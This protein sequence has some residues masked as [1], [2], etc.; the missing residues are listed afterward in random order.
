[1]PLSASFCPGPM[2]PSEANVG[3][4]AATADC[5]SG[6][7][8]VRGPSVVPLRR[9]IPW[10]KL[11]QTRRELRLIGRLFVLARGHLWFLP[12]MA[13]LALLSAV[14]EGISL[15]LVIPLVQHLGGPA[16]PAS[17]FPP[18]AWFRDMIDALPP[19]TRL[20]AMLGA[21]LS[22][23]V[24]KSIVS[25][26]NMAVLGV[27][28]GR[29]SH[30]LRTGIFARILERPL[31][32]VE[33]EPS[34]RLLNVLNSETWRATD[35][36]NFLFTIITSSTTI[37]VFAALL[38]LLSWR[39]SLI[40]LLC[41]AAI[42][43]LI[44]LIARRAKSLS[45]LGLAANE[46]LARHTWTAL[47]GLR[48]IHVFGRE[49]FEARRL[50]ES[51][52][53]VRRQLLKMVLISTASGPVTEVLVT[54]IVA[55]LALLV[56]A[57]QLGLGILAG[58]LAILYRLQPRLV[59]L[60]SAQA[61]LLGLHASVDAVYEVF[62]IPAET[63]ESPAPRRSASLRERVSFE[64]VSFTY[65]GASRPALLDVSLQVRR[66][67]M[68][69]IVGPSGAG[70]STVLDLLLG[71]QRAQKGTIRVDDVPLSACDPVSWRARLAVVSQDPYVFDDTVR[72]NILYGRPGA[73]D[74]QMVAAARLACADGFI[75]ELPMG[76]D[77]VV[78]ERGAQISGGQRQRIALARALVRDP[79]ILVLDEATN[80]LDAPTERAFQDALA[81]FV[82]HRAVLVVAHRLSTVEKAD[83]V[84]VLDQGR[85][86]EEGDPRSLLREGGRFSHM[87]AS[88]ILPSS[89]DD[90]VRRAWAR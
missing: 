58:F 60:V 75:R 43:P 88:Q 64:N 18:L 22:A 52:D 7:V 71:F 54:G 53:G 14:F 90:A 62:A 57:S 45:R 67:S 30:G 26:A 33:R 69:A 89:G 17:L 46:A 39:L 66:G 76:Y 6:P 35:A 87:F 85:V 77:T 23:V 79:D 19:G 40:A 74:A 78:G 70:K 2:R 28:Y 5:T 1:M 4:E 44:Q 81:H 8:G 65:P 27:V 80:A 61:N 34:G 9:P 12:A 56:D 73:T 51:S 49:G 47:N 31:V 59:S 83:H 32:E 48:T 11:R 37:A 15:T 38:V 16:G 50:A 68:L 10:L 84:V 3:G 63:A 20:P 25:Y 29:L 42:P 21:I 72:A 86:V 36:L 82:R 41:M 55:T 13:V 24:A